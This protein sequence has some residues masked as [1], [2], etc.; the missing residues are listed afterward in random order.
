M[1]FYVFA[2]CFKTVASKPE[3]VL[4]AHEGVVSVLQRSPFFKD[5]LLSIGGWT[6]AIWKE[7]VSVSSI[8]KNYIFTLVFCVCVVV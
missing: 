6:F 4:A 3:L 7:G 1:S 2:S 8:A 5:I